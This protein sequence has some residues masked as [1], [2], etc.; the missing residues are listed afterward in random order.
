MAYYDWTNQIQ[1]QTQNADK[2]LCF[3]L[4][5]TWTKFRLTN[6]HSFILD[7]WMWTAHYFV[8]YFVQRWILQRRVCDTF[9]FWC[10][11]LGRGRCC[12]SFVWKKSRNCKLVRGLQKNLVRFY[13]TL[14][15]FNNSLRCIIRDNLWTHLKFPLLFLYRISDYYAYRSIHFL[16]W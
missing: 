15:L 2:F 12:S 6:R 13:G 8:F 7:Y 10:S 4:W 9:T 16:I 11:F 14:D 5:W 1:T 3:L